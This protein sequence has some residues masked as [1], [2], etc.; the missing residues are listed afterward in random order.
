VAVE[1]AKLRTSAPTRAGKRLLLV[2]DEEAILRPMSKY[3]RELGFSVVPARG[4]SEAES[5]LARE[6]FDLLIL[7]L[8]LDPSERGGL[9]VLRAL[10]ASQ[11]STPVVVM[12]A[13]VSH[14]VESEARRLGAR[15]VL[16]KPQPLADV[17][18]AAFNLV[19]E[20]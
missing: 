6:R 5:A 18:L 13:Y 17:A 12:S 19:G 1:D 2:D 20:P 16:R 4:V 14:E 9:D 15:A 8:R 3:F 10:R 11:A 7:D